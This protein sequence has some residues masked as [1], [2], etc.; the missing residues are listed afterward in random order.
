M[1]KVLLGTRCHG[2]WIGARLWEQLVEHFMQH[3]F[4][5]ASILR[6]LQVCNTGYLVLS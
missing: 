6:G 1:D 2:L 4:T 3:D 5:V